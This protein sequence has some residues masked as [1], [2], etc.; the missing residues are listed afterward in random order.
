[1]KYETNKKT[2]KRLGQGKVLIRKEKEG[3]YARY[4][5][6]EKGKEVWC[7]GN[8]T[9]IEQIIANDLRK[10]EADTKE[11]QSQGEQANDPR[12]NH[13]K[14]ANTRRQVLARTPN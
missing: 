12:N 11:T 9:D 1:M 7:L 4:A 6:G 2:I 14:V 13:I 3:F 5:L 8:K 10:Y